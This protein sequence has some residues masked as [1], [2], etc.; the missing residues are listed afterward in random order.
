[1]VVVLIILHFI[2]VKNLKQRVTTGVSPEHSAQTCQCY[3][4]W[5]IMVLQSINDALLH[6]RLKVVTTQELAQEGLFSV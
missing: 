5:Y 2:T 4:I 3:A 1:M 6:S